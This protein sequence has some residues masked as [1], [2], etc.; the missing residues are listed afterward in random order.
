M[1]T[2]F[3]EKPFET[4]SEEDLSEI[5]LYLT[6]QEVAERLGISVEYARALVKAALEAHREAD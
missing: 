3:D 2:V 1:Y 4:S 5:G 6:I